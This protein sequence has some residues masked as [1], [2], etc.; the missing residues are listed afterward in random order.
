MFVVSS[1]HLS[2]LSFKN[3][4]QLVALQQNSV[5]QLVGKQNRKWDF[6]ELGH[7]R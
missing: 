5:G 6:G 7:K 4:M 2:T 1:V 3:E